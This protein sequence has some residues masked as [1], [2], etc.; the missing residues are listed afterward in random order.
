MRTSLDDLEYGRE[1][2]CVEAAAVS[3]VA[4]RLDAS[5]VEALNLLERCRGTVVTSGV[6]KSGL[7]AR[8]AAAT[9][10]ST[11]RPAVF[12]HPSEGMHGDLGIVRAGD[13][14]LAISHS[15]E[16][17]EL[18]AVLPTVLVRQVPMV[19][20]VGSS[21]STLARRATVWLDASVERE[22]C[23]NNLAPTASVLAAIALCDALAAALQR[24]RGYGPEEYAL[25]HPGGQLGRR[26]TLR[27]KDV[28]P[29][30]SQEAPQVCAD[31]SFEDILCTLTSGHMGAVAV[32]GEGGR[33]TGI[34]SEADWRGAFVKR[35]ASAFAL[36]AGAIM[37]AAPAVVLQPGQLAYE[38]MQIMTARPRPVSVAPVVD[39]QGRLT[40]MLRVNDLVRAGL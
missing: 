16:S 5:F 15:G 19:A 40:G 33:L 29:V 24:R 30:G 38:A 13:L 20:I 39:E 32:V 35:G 36:T 12:M 26:L 37:N 11:G 9:L 2:L 8:K 7:A 34:I 17:E 18:L 3:A 4:S 14:M 22:A 27:V 1:A 31:A 23:P 10:T 21:S 25:N 28:M 6:G